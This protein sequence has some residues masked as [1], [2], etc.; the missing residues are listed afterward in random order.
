MDWTKIPHRMVTCGSVLLAQTGVAVLV[1]QAGGHASASLILTNVFASA[2]GGL[3]SNTLATDLHPGTGSL[4]SPRESRPR[5][6]QLLRASAHAASILIKRHIE[7]NCALTGANQGALSSLANAVCRFYDDLGE[8]TVIAAVNEAEMREAYALG[9]GLRT[10]KAQ[11]KTKGW[12]GI[13]LP[14]SR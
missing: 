3:A 4:A 6:H 11:R 9:Q 7:T 5:G 10:K 13:P 1:A 14:F 12:C 8:G 2:L